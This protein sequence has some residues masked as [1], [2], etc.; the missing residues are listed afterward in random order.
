MT[1]YLFYFPHQPPPFLHLPNDKPWQVEDEVT[2]AT[3]DGEGYGRIGRQAQQMPKEEKGGFLHAQR[4]GHGKT[5]RGRALDKRFQSEAIHQAHRVA[6]E[7]K[8]DPDF[9]RAQTP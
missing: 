5:S 1:P 4:A 2:A 9:A 8:A 6:E 3:H 7:I